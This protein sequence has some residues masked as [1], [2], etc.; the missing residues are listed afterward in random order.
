[1]LEK[2]VGLPLQIVFI[3]VIGST[4]GK[5]LTETV[6]CISIEHKVYL[7]SEVPL[8]TP[9]TTPVEGSIVAIFVDPLDQTPPAVAFA[10]V[11]FPPTHKDKVPVIGVNTS[12]TVIVLVLFAEHPLDE[13]VYVI[14][15]VP[16]ACPVTTPV[17]GSIVAEAGVPL[18]Q[19]PEDIASFNVIVEPTH[20]LDIPPI[21]GTT[22]TAV[23][24][25][26][27]VIGTIQPPELTV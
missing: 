17:T 5:A 3:P 18:L 14:N 7:I 11:V 13:T 8:D 2:V 20:T 15:V 9:V 19:T 1:M 4:I 24:F 21:A 23:I 25:T 26:V 22:G 16:F 10:K 12:T 6:V 27:A